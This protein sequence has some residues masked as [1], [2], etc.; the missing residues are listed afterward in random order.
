MVVVMVV[1]FVASM[2]RYLIKLSFYVFSSNAVAK[3]NELKELVS[4]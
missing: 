4:R 1:E 2:L 3:D